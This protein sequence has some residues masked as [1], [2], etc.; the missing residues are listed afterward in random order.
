M[1]SIPLFLGRQGGTY[2]FLLENPNKKTYDKNQDVINDPIF[3]FLGL[4][5]TF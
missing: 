3:E 4:L 1:D 2:A 5:F